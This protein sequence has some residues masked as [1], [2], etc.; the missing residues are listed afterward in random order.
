MS[1]S[2]LIFLQKK[3]PSLSEIWD[4]MVNK[5]E[6]HKS[7][8]CCNKLN[9]VLMRKWQPLD[10]DLNEGWRVVNQIVIPDQCQKTLHL[11]H[12]PSSGCYGRPSWN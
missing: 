6:E 2:E 12:Q 10:S 7:A 3:D 5:S 11:A 8:M 4:V 1:S 9:G